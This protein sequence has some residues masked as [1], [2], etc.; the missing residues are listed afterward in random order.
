MQIE[1]R[2][3]WIAR[4]GG[5]G[6]F[7]T[8]GRS[9]ADVDYG[10]VVHSG[11][12]RRLQ[13]KTQILNLGD[14]DFYRNRLTHS[15]EVAQIAG[16]I[17][18]YLGHTYPKHGAVDFLPDLSMIQAVGFTHDL[19]H[20]PFGHGGEVALNYCM[21]GHGGF[22]GNGQTLRILSRLEK[23]SENHGA[24]LARRTLLG[25]LKY[26]VPFS[27]A[28]NPALRPA[29]VKGPTALTLIDRAVSKPPKCYLDSE[30]DV[31][32]WI[33]EP[34][35][36]GDRSRF[37]AFSAGTDKHNKPL[38]KSFDCS[39]MDLADDIGFG[40]HDLEDAVA[41]G[42]ISKTDFCK[43]VPPEACSVYLNWLLERYKSDAGNNV[44]NYFVEMLF[45]DGR[46]RK[47]CISR[48]VN[49]LIGNCHIETL[50]EFEEPLLRYRA[51][52][53]PEPRKFLQ[54]LKDAVHQLVISSPSVQHLEFK[55]QRMVVAVFETFMTEPKAFLPRDTYALYEKA[56]D[57]VRVICDHISGMTDSFLLK[58]Y[59]RLFSPRMGSIFDRL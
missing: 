6:T 8:E 18:K 31:V 29:P 10:R 4:H 47:R 21:R 9:W 32:D 16:G 26:P 27:K 25:V 59:E 50:D 13:G 23:F 41:M 56:G 33:L 52:M 35:S 28:A 39:I 24:D 14:S 38:H 42:L 17:T 40:V 20:P 19:G 30:Q 58:T 5:G 53:Q 36:A 3:D 12:F 48:M 34:L 37:T 55:G 57:P 45:S 43:A 2:P 46:A 44:Y 7:S 22:E 49:F 1:K 54:A 15:L 11:S 51:A